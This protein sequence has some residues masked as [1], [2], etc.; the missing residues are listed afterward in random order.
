MLYN[1]CFW[2]WLACGTTAIF[3]FYS[4]HTKSYHDRMWRLSYSKVF[5]ERFYLGLIYGA[6]LT[7][8]SFAFAGLFIFTPDPIITYIQSVQP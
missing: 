4:T 7:A 8:T 5:R 1:I 6:L 3:I 2:I